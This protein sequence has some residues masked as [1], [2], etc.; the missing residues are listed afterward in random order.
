MNCIVSVPLIHPPMP[1]ANLPHLSAA[2][3][4]HTSLNHG[5]FSSWQYLSSWPV[6]WSSTEYTASVSL[7]LCATRL[8]IDSVWIGSAFHNWRCLALTRAAI[9]SANPSIYLDGLSMNFGF[10]FL[11]CGWTICFCNPDGDSYIP[12]G[13]SLN[14]TLGTSWV[15]LLSTL[16]DF[17]LSASLIVLLFAGCSVC[18]ILSNASICA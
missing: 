4:F 7:L 5:C 10:L 16:R 6:S 14:L 2:D 9:T 13:L 15:G 1:W 12:G 17:T 18:S 8:A 11:A 3:L